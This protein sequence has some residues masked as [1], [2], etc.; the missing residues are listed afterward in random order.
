[1]ALEAATRKE[2]R[3]ERTPRV[4]WAE[5]LRRTFAVEVFACMNCGGMR[6]VLAYVKGAATHELT[7]ARSGELDVSRGFEDALTNLLGDIATRIVL[8]PSTRPKTG[9]LPRCGHAPKGSGPPRRRR[10]SLGR[11]PGGSSPEVE[12]EFQ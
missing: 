7:H 1:M 2:P 6:R 8:S 3:R 9:L 4:N 5:L 10:A 12:C 11:S